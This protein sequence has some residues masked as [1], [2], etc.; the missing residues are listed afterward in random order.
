[1]RAALIPNTCLFL[2]DL[3]KNLEQ[4]EMSGFP[5]RSKS[6]TPLQ[7]IQQQFTALPFDR[8]TFSRYSDHCANCANT[9]P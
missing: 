1:M 6:P 3:S 5:A 2:N 4:L 7:L 9:P 8:E